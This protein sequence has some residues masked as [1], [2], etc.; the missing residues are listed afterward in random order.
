MVSTVQPAHVLANNMCVCAWQDNRMIQLIID[1][2][3][4]GVH[5]AIVTAAGYPGDAERFEQRVQGLLAAFRQQRL[6]DH[7]T[8]RCCSVARPPRPRCS[9]TSA[10]QMAGSNNSG[11]AGA[12]VGAPCACCVPTHW[13]VGPRRFH[14]MGGECNYLL[15]VS[16]APE[17]RLQFVPDG[18]WKTEY[19]MGWRQGDIDTVLNE[20]GALLQSTASHLRL[21]VEVWQQPLQLYAHLPVICL[22]DGS[23]SLLSRLRTQCAQT[24]WLAH[25]CLH[26]AT[27]RE[28]VVLGWL[29]IIR[30]ERSVGVKPTVPTIYEV[31]ARSCLSTAAYAR[32]TYQD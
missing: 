4:L 29:Q 23:R 14:M 8:D 17:R 16:P 30:K 2:M 5:V 10:L 7:I 26:H 32:R 15:R 22:R 9:W 27:V 3:N 24:L 20:A 31:A 18:H 6:P 1:L 12:A 11:G 13:R 21:P 19:M 28:S 25:A